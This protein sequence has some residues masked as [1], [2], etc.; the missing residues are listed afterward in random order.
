MRWRRYKG[1]R[2]KDLGMRCRGYKE[3]DRKAD[4]FFS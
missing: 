2:D 1:K 4:A 3:L